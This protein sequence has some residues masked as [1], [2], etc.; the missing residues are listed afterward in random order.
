MNGVIRESLKLFHDEIQYKSFPATFSQDF[1]PFP[2]NVSLFL[3]FNA[4]DY[5]MLESIS[6]FYAQ[7]GDFY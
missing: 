2:H 5:F 7:K 1:V 6:S 4:S 3:T